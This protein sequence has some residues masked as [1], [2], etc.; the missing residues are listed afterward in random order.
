MARIIRVLLVSA[1]FIFTVCRVNCEPVNL[2]TLVTVQN[3]PFE[4]CTKIFNMDSENLF[5]L[6]IAG[7]N[8][9]R[10]Q[11]DEI[12]SK[13]GYIL[14]NA[15]NKEFLASV[16]KLDS[17]NSLLRVTPANNVYYFQPGIVLNLFKYIELNGSVKPVVLLV[18]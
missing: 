5:Y 9:N 8:A 14:F 7:I 12:Q 11:I 18:K 10:F 2:S 3:V 4:Q 16:V 13:T 17:K 6:T 1:C 15:V